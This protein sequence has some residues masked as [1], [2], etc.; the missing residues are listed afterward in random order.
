MRSTV[1][2]AFSFPQSYLYCNLHR[3]IVPLVRYKIRSS[4]TSRPPNSSGRSF[5]LPTTPKA[6]IPPIPYFS[7][8]G[9]IISSI[10]AISAKLVLVDAPLC[11]VEEE[12]GDQD[13]M[14][15]CKAARQL[16]TLTS[17]PHRSHAFLRGLPN[18][19]NRF[20]P[21]NDTTCKAFRKTQQLR[22]VQSSPPDH[23]LIFIHHRSP[24]MR[25][26]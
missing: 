3:Q 7:P 19:F 22:Y 20:K 25:H 8:K 18:L 5:Q 17:R 4:G 24:M 21:V 6:P 26:P 12:G 1:E 11:L 15:S 9:P 13:P 23:T 2:S 16:P 14:A 10:V